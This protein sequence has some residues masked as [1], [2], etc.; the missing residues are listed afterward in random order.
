MASQPTDHTYALLKNLDDNTITWAFTLISNTILTGNI[1]DYVLD[2]TGS[3]RSVS[4]LK[5]GHVNR[6]IDIPWEMVQYA[7]LKSRK[8]V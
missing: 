2:N 5:V 4:I 6:Y 3:L 1:V 8:M 7:E